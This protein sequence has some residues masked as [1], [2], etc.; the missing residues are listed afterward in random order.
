MKSCPVIALALSACAATPPPIDPVPPP[1]A[2]VVPEP[3]RDTRADDDIAD[4]EI[5][6]DDASP[7]DADALTGTMDM[8]DSGL[9]VVDLRVGSGALAKIG[10]R[11]AVHYDGYLAD[12][13]SFDSSR[14]RGRPF[15]LEL[16]AGHVIKGWEEG[17]VGM[18]EGGLRRLIIP[19]HLGY[20]S[21]NVGSIPPDSILEFEIE[22]LEVK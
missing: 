21:R 6:V 8:R 17:L 14:K 1:P 4:A 11:V 10:D 19:P 16:G 12:G 9:G 18:R 3:S 13:Q 20:G 22:L 5:A 7:D 2:I 15:E